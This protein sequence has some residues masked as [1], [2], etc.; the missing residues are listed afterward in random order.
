MTTPKEAL[1]RIIQIYERNA[2]RQNEKLADIPLVARRALASFKGDAVERVARIKSLLASFHRNGC[3][4]EA[5]AGELNDA[6]E[7]II[8]TALLPDEAAIRAAAF[9]EAAKIAE[10]ECYATAGRQIAAAIRSN[11][12]EA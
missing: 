4:P 8:A 10:T 3:Y 2:G 1:E 7:S 9:E 11:R 6:A 5:M 12:R